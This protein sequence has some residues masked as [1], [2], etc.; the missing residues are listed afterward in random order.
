M[1]NVCI[2]KR[3]SK[4]A[5]DY[6]SHLDHSSV[7]FRKGNE[8]SRWTAIGF[9]QRNKCMAKC[10]YI[11]ISTW[12]PSECWSNARVYEWSSRAC[13]N[14]TNRR[15]EQKLGSLDRGNLGAKLKNWNH[16]NESTKIDSC[17]LTKIPSI[18][19]ANWMQYVLQTNRRVLE[20]CYASIG[21]K[22]TT[23]DSTSVGRLHCKQTPIC[24]RPAIRSPPR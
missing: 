12:N 7:I 20:K 10:R 1:P 4:S 13:W 16:L 18:N 9:V 8:P 6:F 5:R 22:W 11:L 17:I 24:T 23:R 2:C 3:N 21:L 15:D 14:T 19:N